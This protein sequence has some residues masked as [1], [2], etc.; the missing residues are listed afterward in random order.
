MYSTAS[1]SAILRDT[2]Q[3]LGPV[4]QP[5][6]TTG[7]RRPLSWQ[8]GDEVQTARLSI[9]KIREVS[10]LGVAWHSQRIIAQSVGIGQSSMRDYLGRARLAGTSW[11]KE[12]AD[13]NLDRLVHNAYRI[14]L[15]GEAMRK[16]SAN[17]TAVVNSD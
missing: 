6:R 4:G 9:R 15:K 13:A 8:G 17:L 10:R 3:F 7:Y 16:K 2:S 5:R 12:L 14:K 1:W 11:P